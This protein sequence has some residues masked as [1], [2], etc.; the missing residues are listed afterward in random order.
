[1]PGIVLEHEKWNPISRHRHN[2]NFTPYLIRYAGT[3][4][5]AYAH[6][7]IY[8]VYMVCNA[9]AFL[10]SLAIIMLVM[11]GPVYKD[12]VNVHRQAKLLVSTLFCAITFLIGSYIAVFI[13]MSPPFYDYDNMRT[14]AFSSV[15]GALILWFSMVV[16]L[17]VKYWKQ[18]NDTSSDSF[19]F[20]S[21]EFMLRILALLYM[22]AIAPGLFLAVYK[23]YTR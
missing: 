3:P 23:F 11:T 2:A 16:R 4:I 9:T 12:F 18:I 13:A 5:L 17:K 6:P 8:S 14:L 20:I 1:S 7:N 22:F 19:K 15:G 21:R 10:M